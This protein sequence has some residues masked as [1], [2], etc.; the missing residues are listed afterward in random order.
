M[1]PADITPSPKS[2]YAL[3]NSI[4]PVRRAW[5]QV[6]RITIESIGLSVPVGT[7][8]LM[9]HRYG[10]DIAQKDLALA[11]GVNSGALVR[12]LDQAE[13]ANLL[14]RTD[15]PNDRRCKT[16]NL[17]PDGAEIALQI[18]QRLQA[19]RQD[20]FSDLAEADIETATRVLRE[21]EERAIA[22]AGKLAK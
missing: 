21:L 9:T 1:L 2:L 17:M 19:V 4:Q 10:P 18:E 13:Q 14:Q 6:A 20:L 22:K 12:T 7:A 11:V 5:L 16:V 3:T 15:S 8:V